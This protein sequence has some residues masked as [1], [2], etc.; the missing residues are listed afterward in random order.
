MKPIYK[1]I[2]LFSGAGGFAEGFTITGRFRPVLGID[3]YRPAA[4]SYISN[5]PYS[6]FIMEDIKQVMS[7]DITGIIGTGSYDIVIGSPPCEPFTGANP[8]RQR[9][10]LDRLYK[11]PAGQLTLHFIRI[12]SVLKPHIFVMENVPAIMDD[13]L[14]K[15]LVY[16]FRRAGYPTIFFNILRAENY[17]TPSHRLRVFISNIRIT[18][19]PLNRRIRVREALSDLPP[20]GSFPPNHEPPPPLSRRKLKRVARL[21]KG[22]AMIYYEGARGKRLPNLIRL[23]PDR[24]A[25]TVLG[26]SRFIHPWE[27]RFLTV[28]E[29]AR[30]MGFPDQF[31]FYGG[32]DEQYNQVGE[33]VPVP[34]A[35]AIAEFIA[36]ALD[37]GGV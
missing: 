34:L 13:G 8:R 26:S 37:S 24:I 28:R 6:Y 17:G 36:E 25:P 4:L 7:N 27:D 19:R 33:A 12:I 35:A 30:L 22:E 5:F 16:E 15:A 9:R 32:R 21:R 29:Q 2:D 1:F 11:D 18:P 23:D 10:P 3:N 31:V 20:P 14:K